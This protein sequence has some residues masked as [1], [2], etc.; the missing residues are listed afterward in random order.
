[1][2]S[3]TFKILVSY[4]Q[5]KKFV[6]SISLKEVPSRKSHAFQIPSTFRRATEWDNSEVRT[7]AILILGDEQ[8]FE[9][10]FK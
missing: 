5:I 4:E 10:G 6:L 2:T 1:M 8:K 7:T 9:D 3:Y